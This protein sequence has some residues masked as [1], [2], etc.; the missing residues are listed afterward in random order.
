M[1]IVRL[2]K[3]SFSGIIENKNTS[4]IKGRTVRYMKLASMRKNI[5]TVGNKLLERLLQFKRVLLYGVIGLSAL[6]LEVAIFYA[7]SEQLN[8]GVLVGNAAGMLAG[9]IFAFVLN[10]RY[11]FQVTDRGVERFFRYGLVAFGGFI[12]TSAIIFGITHY[13]GITVIVAKFMSLPPYFLFQYNAHRLF[14]FHSPEQ[15]ATSAQEN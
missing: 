7:L 5:T 11:N 10:A 1:I 4:I 15:L 3:C 8:A 12:L 13:T 14:T 6:A 2:I 9:L